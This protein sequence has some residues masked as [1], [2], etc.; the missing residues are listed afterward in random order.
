MEVQ[1]GIGF[2]DLIATISYAAQ[3]VTAISVFV[4]AITLLAKRG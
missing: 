3:I 1:S 2:I 4:I